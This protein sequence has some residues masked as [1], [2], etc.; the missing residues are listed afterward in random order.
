MSLF[1][2]REVASASFLLK[3]FHSKGCSVVRISLFLAILTFKICKIT[4][5]KTLT[6][7][8]FQ[9]RIQFLDFCKGEL[10]SFSENFI[11]NW[12]P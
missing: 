3:F 7:N 9:C 2:Y 10:L 12:R 5:L 8:T 11:G 1:S 4:F 6:N